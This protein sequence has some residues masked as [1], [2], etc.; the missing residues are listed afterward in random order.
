[1]R[2]KGYISLRI[3][4]PALFI[5]GAM[6]IGSCGGGGSGSGDS[7]NGQNYTPP[8]ECNLD[9]QRNEHRLYLEGADEG[10][11]DYYPKRFS[12]DFK[13]NYGAD[14]SPTEEHEDIARKLS[15]SVLE[16]EV[17]EI[18][19]HDL[20]V[21]SAWLIAPKYVVTA[22]HAFIHFRT[23]IKKPVERVFVHT[24]DG[25]RIEAEIVYVDE[26]VTNA[27]DLAL[28]RVE[29]EID[30]IPLKIADKMPAKN[31]FLMA[32]GGGQ[33][34]KGLGG[35]TVS[36]GPALELKKGYPLR[37]DR[38]Y[39]AVPTSGGMS[40]GPIFNEDGEVV[41]IV[42][43]G[44]GEAE[45]AIREG[46]GVMPSEVRKNDLPEN[47]WVYAFEQPHPHVYS[48][49]P[50][51]EQIKKLYERIPED[52][53]PHN[54]GD[55]SD[56]NRW[57]AG[58]EFGNNEFD[59]YEFADKYSPFPLDQFDRM[60]EKYKE[61][62][63]GTVTITIRKGDSGV[64]G[65]GFIYDENTI[66]TVGHLG[67]EKGLKAEII[68]YDGE[69]HYGEVVKRQYSG[70]G[71]CDIAVIKMDKP[72]SGYHNLEIADES[73]SPKCGDPLVTIGSGE[74]Y[75]NVGRLQGVGAVY[76]HT[77][78][79]VSE[80]ISH[81]AVPGMSGG[82]VVDRNG[83]VVSISSTSAGRVGEEGE[84]AKPGPLVVRTRLPVYIGQDFS[85]GPNAETIK[86]FVT[87][88]GYRCP[89]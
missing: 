44:S 49:G 33:S 3:F 14:I 15:R 32:M 37:T 71:G 53:R 6:G 61:A 56:H 83:K 16:I 58:D 70:L 40:G 67:I 21:G 9:S 7:G 82:P 80:F 30:A 55:Y 1:M 52:E 36:A 26:K 11:D 72:L 66:V 74:K 47:L 17:R 22:A 41:S 79:Y 75:N 88:K 8:P 38:M 48:A 35:W 54:A 34:Q 2:L 62:R 27:T 87:E 45:D 50:N 68:T 78:T 60:N 4:L 65:S 5:L 25:D 42:S 23:L 76:M 77:E 69:E 64:F 89:E 73:S 18:N 13:E 39:H 20:G 81:F 43:A 28:L 85:E 86:R 46:F 51:I 59:N 57:K 10:R 31:E 63:E 12:R 24:F 29:K 19:S 84:W